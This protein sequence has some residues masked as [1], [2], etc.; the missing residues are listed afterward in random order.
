MDR[1]SW[2]LQSWNQPKGSQRNSFSVKWTFQSSYVWVCGLNQY[3]EKKSLQ[4]SCHVLP[5]TFKLTPKGHV[6]GAA[7]RFEF[8]V[9]KKTEVNCQKSFKNHEMCQGPEKVLGHE[10]KWG[11]KN[12]TEQDA[13]MDGTDGRFLN[14]YCYRESLAVHLWSTSFIDWFTVC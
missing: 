7:S 13:R 2:D 8:W 9:P 4:V 5:S 12:L 1:I 14:S 11:S 3:W 6:R 10:K